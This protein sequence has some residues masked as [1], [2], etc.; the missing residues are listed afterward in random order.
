MVELTGTERKVLPLLVDYRTN[1][2]IAQKLGFEERTAKFHVSNI[3]R[4]FGV[5]GRTEF[6]RMRD[7]WRL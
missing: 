1:K 7:K 4:K 6:W 2:E 5:Q 3:L